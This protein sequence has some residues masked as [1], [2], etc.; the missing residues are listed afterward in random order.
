[1]VLNRASKK[2][3][4]ARLSALRKA[5]SLQVFTLRYE[6]TAC[7]ETRGVAEELAETTSRLSVEINDVLESGDLVRR[8][9]VDAIPAIVATAKEAPE[10]CIYGVPT[11]FGLLALLEGIVALGAP[12]E[13]GE[14]LM[15]QL[16]ESKV[17]PGLRVDLVCSRRDQACAEAASALWRV[18]FASRYAVE[19]VQPIFSLR[20]LEDNPHFIHGHKSLPTL[21][22]DGKPSLVWPFA[23]TDIAAALS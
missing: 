4:D 1:M 17:R 8:Y 12:K 23:D 6:D 15:D 11:A 20:I 18:A 19:T 7:R 5:V 2:E 13:P 10:L 16:S 3:A 9:R 14:G 21:L 22:T